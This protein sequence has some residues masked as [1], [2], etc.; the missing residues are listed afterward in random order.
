M[1]PMDV[2]QSTRDLAIRLIILI[3]THLTLIPHTDMIV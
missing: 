2:Q 1:Y 3:L